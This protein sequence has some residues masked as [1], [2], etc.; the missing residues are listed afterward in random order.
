MRV[1]AVGECMLELSRQGDLWRLGAAGDSFNT[2]LYLRRLGAEVRYFTVLG[3]DPFSEEMLASWGQEGIDTSLVLRDPSR[4]PGLYAIR[5]DERGERSFYYWR[6]NAAVRQ[7][8]RLPGTGE[9]LRAAE[10]C[11]LLYIT[12]ITLSLFDAADRQR[13]AALAAQVRARGGEVAF[14]PNYRARGWSDVC[15]ARQAI[16]SLASQVSIVLTTNDDEK[17]L[18]G[19][20]DVDATFAYWQSAGVREVVVKRGAHGATVQAQSGSAQVPVA[21]PVQV[22]D[23]TGA[24]DSFNAAYLAARFRGA[25][26]VEAARAGNL[27]AGTVVQVR[28]AILPVAQMPSLMV[29]GP[30][31]R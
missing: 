12:G 22:I 16:E 23:S 15:E 29:G 28:G 26:C 21:D 5:T 27:L 20:Q 6:Q 30:D 25:D 8:F 10:H 7:L 24:G 13:I 19:H 11:D 18:F 3:Q 1:V 31:T 9:A 4:L 14:D 2:S 17:S